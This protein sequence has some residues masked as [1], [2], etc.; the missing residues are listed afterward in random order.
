[1]R[2][3]A[4][5]VILSV[6]VIL[7]GW[8][9]SL[10]AQ[11]APPADDSRPFLQVIDNEP[12]AGEELAPGQPIVLY[13]DRA[14]DCATASAAVRLDGAPAPVQC[15]NNTLTLT[16][17]WKRGEV[18]NV[19]VGDS[20]R[21]QDGATLAEPYALTLATSG[22]LQVTTSIPDSGATEFDTLSPVTLVFNRPVVP[23]GALGDMAQQAVSVSLE[24]PTAFTTEWVNTA[25]LR[26][27]PVDGWNGGTGYRLRLTELNAL[28]GAPLAQ[29]FEMAFTTEAPRVVSAEPASNITS[30]GTLPGVPLDQPISITFN[31]PVDRASFEANFSLTIGGMVS[32]PLDGQFIWNASSTQVTYRHGRPFD[33]DT[34]YLFEWNDNAVFERS[35]SVAF[36]RFSRQFVTVSA[37]Q[38]LYT[39]PFDGSEVA[40]G[41]GISIYFN[42]VMNPETLRERIIIDPQPERE[43]TFF[44]RTWN[45]SYGINISALPST[46]YTITLLPGMEDIYGNVI[47]ETY[48]FSY[49]TRA[50]SPEINLLVP[51]NVSGFYDAGRTPTELYA[52]HLNVSRLDLRLQRVDVQALL[53]AMRTDS[54]MS[55][56]FDPF[57][58][59]GETL[60]QWTIPSIAPLNVTRYERLTPAL[61]QTGGTGG[62]PAQIDCPGAPP[63]RAKV[64]DRAVVITDPDPLRA[65]QAPRDGAII[66]LLYNG[67]AFPITGGP[68]CLNGILWWQISLRDGQSAW[69]AEGIDDEYFFEITFS[70]DATQID[71]PS[72]VL[73]AD[74]RL[75][76]GVYLLS[77]SAPEVANSRQNQHLMIVGTANITLK[78]GI[79]SVALWVTDVRSGQPLANVPVTLYDE[80]GSYPLTTDADGIATTR[81]PR[82]DNL[83]RAVAALVDDG[84]NFGIGF[85]EWTDGIDPW[86]FGLLYNYYPPRYIGNL[87]SDRSV[88][89]PGQTVYYRGVIRE[90]DDLRYRVPQLGEL[91]L[92]VFDDRGTL[93]YEES[94]TLSD[95][96][97]FSGEFTLADDSVLGFYNIEVELPSENE[98]FREAVGLSFDVAQYRLP[99]F[100]VRGTA[101]TPTVTGEQPLRFAFDAEFF[102]GGAVADATLDYNVFWEDYNFSYRGPGRY[103]FVSAAPDGFGFFFPFNNFFTAGSATTD[104]QGQAVIEFVPRLEA[105]TV[106]GSQTFTVEATVLDSTGQTVSGRASAIV[107]GAAVYA[108]IGFE[109]YVTAAGDE[110][111]A[112][113]IVVDWDSAPVG[114]VPLEIEVY[115][116]TWSTV[117]RLD[118]N[119]MI[120]T[121]SEPEDTLVASARLTSDANGRA[122]FTFVPASGGYHYARVTATDR[123][124]NRARASESLWVTS[125]DFVAW[126]VSNDQ[127]IDLIADRQDYAI[128]DT[129]EIL[130]TTPFTGTAEAWITVERAG[131]LRSERLTLES[132]STVYR[133]PI[134]EDFAPNAFVSVFVVKGVGENQ[135]VADFRMGI[136]NLKVDP[137][138]R[139]L[140]LTLSADRDRTE[141]GDTIR[142]TVRATDHTGAPVVAEIGAGVTDLAA[143]SI[144]FDYSQ[145]LF[146]TFYGLQA[147]AVRTAALLTINTDLITQFTLDVI[148]GGGG[149]G[150]GGGIFEIREEFIDTPLWI[151]ALVTDADGTASFDLTLPDNLT[152]WRLDVRGVTRGDDGVMLIGQETLDIVST[153]PV[154]VRPVTPRFFVVD[155]RVLIGAVVNNNTAQALEVEVDL[156]ASG[157]S[158]AE[159]DTRQVVTVPASSTARVNW[160]VTAQDVPAVELIFFADAENGR[161]TDA[162]RPAVGQGDE[163]LLPV[164]RYVA[165]EVIGTGGVISEPTSRVEGVVLPR[166][167]DEQQG[168]F[169]ISLQTSLA[170]AALDGLTYLRAHPCQC[171]TLTINQLMANS[172]TRRALNE[173]SLS[174]PALI[175]QLDREANIAIQRLAAQQQVGGG[176]GWYPAAPPDTLVSAMGLLALISA[177]EAGYTV[178]PEILLNAI[179]Y[180]QAN[181]DPVGSTRAQLNRQAFLLYALAQA[182]V[183]DVA[184]MSNLIDGGSLERIDLY[185]RG[186][187]LM[188]LPPG[189]TARRALLR[190]NLLG[191]VVLTANGAHWEERER[192]RFNWNSDTRTT[193]IILRALLAH[194]PANDLLPNVVRWL[195]V[196]RT[197]DAWET[198]EETAWA[199]WTLA[200]WMI[201]TG[202]LDADFGYSVSLND[203]ILTEGRATPDD[204]TLSETIR[205]PLDALERGALNRLVFTR[206]VGEGRLYYTE[207]L[208]VFLPVPEIEPVSRGVFITRQYISR[209]TG[210]PVTSA[211]IGE[212]VDVRL[213]ITAPNDLNFLIIDDPLP[214]GMEG[215]DPRLQTA[216]QFVSD[217]GL[218]SSSISETGWGWWLFDNISFQDDR[219]TISASY[220]PRGT[221]EYVYQARA[222]IEGT[223]NVIPPTGGELYFPEVYGRG[224]G[225]IFTVLPAR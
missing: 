175:S 51:M 189:D 108:G 107:H 98:F 133:L 181:I 75:P 117:Q 180:L 123:D 34:P 7:L 125:G 150:G 102:F 210:Q 220:L 14:L 211:R 172:A 2:R 151:G 132:N 127:R 52:T 141:P 152:T 104:S 70:A 31:Q 224:A 25:I 157:L 109:S 82:R 201:A 208:R 81:I 217:P 29:A 196:A 16:G 195:M 185:A 44:Y 199:V 174:D 167:F 103:S 126:R 67:Y 176:W 90:N 147:L 207:Y 122:R 23:L 143:L 15:A 209:A 56:M 65:R 206:G 63:S 170:S 49:T 169:T 155:D 219:V 171:L 165:P 5:S 177:S 145:P 197:A 213:T 80:I 156:L 38:I 182:G 203:A 54:G 163:R 17:E 22:F 137:A 60:R 215:V 111:T 97:T 84:T 61:A 101:L 153:K 85:S 53:N 186:L 79:D 48:T 212:V 57:S 43:P 28:D 35:G 69:V 173:L 21:A 193:A 94:I 100:Q 158:F 131:I 166:R 148:K 10:T 114:G 86:R 142:Y 37:P 222:S 119:G 30:E 8:S 159:S 113:L 106:T 204:A 72:D 115:Q 146:E 40:P 130:I 198:I 33:L 161:F 93:V 149:G 88:Y 184:R 45:N 190:D 218:A 6:C 20:L 47:T 87:Y 183:P 105:G 78:T 164:R 118:V 116:R 92:K 216:E 26:I 89:R 200:D 77:A 121:D 202:E 27:A 205:L 136:V 110:T 144:G 179:S 138:R 71:I 168:E 41:G 91:P 9:A 192:D 154:L 46:R 68:A 221:Y 139:Q 66:D 1:M 178:D 64:G 120:T 62:V 223:F 112:D 134:T 129:A 73:T 187:L 36:P 99:E 39:D 42:T 13:F 96:G 124:G 140:T 18:V 76:A 83:Y 214:A 32:V 4:L 19:Q 12:F 225:S 59:G 3:P 55:F 160:S 128:G 50:L 95:F 11:D 191:A 194:E 24:P 58:L 162:T 74:G 135:K 188:S